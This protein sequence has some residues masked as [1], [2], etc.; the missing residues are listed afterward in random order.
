[1]IYRGVKAESGTYP[2]PGTYTENRPVE[3]P[4]GN[5]VYVPPALH[6]NY[7]QPQEVVFCSG[8]NYYL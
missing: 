3:G 7:K 4:D 1:M 2:E 5:T 6:I 8:Y